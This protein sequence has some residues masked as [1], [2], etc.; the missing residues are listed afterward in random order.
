[1]VR[2]RMVWY[3]SPSEI[4][5]SKQL[6]IEPPPLFPPGFAISGRRPLFFS[7]AAFSR[8]FRVLR[9][10]DPPPPCAQAFPGLGVFSASDRTLSCG[11]R[12]SFIR[13]FH[14]VTL[15]RRAF[16]CEVVFSELF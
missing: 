3:F 11:R 4:P 8:E 13:S 9:R 15:V 10:L 16:D 14:R 1:M 2:W 6:V 7:S 12:R 5:F